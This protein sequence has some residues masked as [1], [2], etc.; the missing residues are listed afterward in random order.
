MTIST[1][2]VVICL[3]IAGV[4]L[5]FFVWWK[6]RH[7]EPRH[8]P[9]ARTSAT[10]PDEPHLV[11]PR[12]RSDEPD[13]SVFFSHRRDSHHAIP[14]LMHED[15][16]ETPESYGLPS[17][18][19]ANDD[20]E[21]TRLSILHRDP[22]CEAINLPDHDEHVVTPSASAVSSNFSGYLS[23][24]SAVVDGPSIDYSD[25]IITTNVRFDPQSQTTTFSM[26]VV[27]AGGRVEL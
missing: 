25:A 18:C 4:L 23:E 13:D 7:R 6:N 26:A 1:T 24:V 20:V 17:N 12:L 5:G 11:L 22:P 3:A 15:E 14:I 8:K 16:M 21:K 19:T 2:A 9:P 10:C 27:P